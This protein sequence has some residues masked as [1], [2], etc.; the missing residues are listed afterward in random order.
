[1]SKALRAEFKSSVGIRLL[2]AP[3]GSFLMGSPATEDGHRAWEQQREVTFSN[4]FYLGKTPVT[5]DQYQAVAGTSPTADQNIGDAPVVSVTWDQ[6]AEFCRK[7]TQ[8][9][10]AAGVLTDDWEYRL[11]TEAEWEYAC[12]AG[13]SAARHGE[14]HEVAWYQDNADGKPHAVG[15]KTPNAWGFQDLLGNVW[16]W[17]QDCFFVSCCSAG[18]RSVRGGS[19]RSSA[20]FCR[21]AQRWGFGPNGRSRYCGFRFLAA[22]TGASFELSP[23]VGFPAQEQTPIYNAIDVNDFDLARRIITAD[24]DEIEPVYVVPPPLHC[25]AYDDNLEWLEWLLDHGAD[26]EGR[27]QDYGSP[28]LTAAIV[29]RQKRIIRTLIQRGADATRAMNCAQ[30][31]LA[32]AYEDDPRLDREGYR[33]IVELL[34]ELG[35]G[36]GK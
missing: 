26:I 20:R 33:E 18:C 7:L 2:R 13:S 5:R 10:R 11:P 12:R 32:G 17:C 8:L 23:P 19:C 34:Q 28:P 1:M 16:E 24:P 35:I 22:K 4:D 36:A 30:R 21:C 27:E 9:D 31:G 25:C 29:H 3:A 15:Q 6:A 14:P